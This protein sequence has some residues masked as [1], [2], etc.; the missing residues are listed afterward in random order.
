MISPSVLTA[1]LPFVTWRNWGISFRIAIRIVFPA[2]HAFGAPGFSTAFSDHV[3][4][5]EFFSA[6]FLSSRFSRQRDA[7]EE[8]RVEVPWGSLRLA[9]E[10]SWVKG[11]SDRGSMK[12]CDRVTQSPHFHSAKMVVIQAEMLDLPAGKHLDYY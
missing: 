2:E 10:C 11:E 9:G 1:A 12:C 3:A 4:V 8:R 6:G 7:L 5:R